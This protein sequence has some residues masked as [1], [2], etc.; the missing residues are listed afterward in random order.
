MDIIDEHLMTLS[1]NTSQSAAIRALVGMAKKTLNR[2]YT[3]TD[4]LELYCIAMSEF[5]LLCMCFLTHSSP[6]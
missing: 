1:L 2:Y 4:D 5:P 6:L 3:K